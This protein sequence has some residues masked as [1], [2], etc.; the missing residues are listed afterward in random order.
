MDR[1]RTAG[2]ELSVVA[3]EGHEPG[4]TDYRAELARIKAAD[5]DALLIWSHATDIGYIAKQAHEMGLNVPMATL[6]E[7]NPEAIEVAGAEHVEG[8]LLGA[9]FF[10][11]ESERP[12]VRAFV[13]GYTAWAGEAPESMGAN[14]YDITY[15]MFDAIKYVMD[16]G[17]D[18]FDGEQLNQAI[19]DKGSFRTLYGDGTMELLES[20][21]VIKT[22][23]IWVMENGQHVLI[24]TLTP[25]ASSHYP[26]AK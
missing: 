24:K 3:S 13:E 26:A 25:P 15:I 5:P 9:E 6:A 22:A 18:P 4:N 10:D 23:G 17:G 20:G 16:N 11:V 8:M 7:I 2:I 21:T 19:L 14:Y 1:L 12:E